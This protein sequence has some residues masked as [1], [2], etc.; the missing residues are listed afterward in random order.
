MK[1][2]QMTFDEYQ[3]L[4]RRTQNK[5]LTYVQRQYHALHGLV[6]E[7]GEIHGL[8]Q[9]IYQGHPL[10]LDDLEKEIGDLL[11]FV[12]ELCDVYDWSM[13]DVAVENI[14]KLKK[15][16]PEGFDA[17]RSVHREEYEDGSKEG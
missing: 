10:S 11:W 8:F 9:K 2:K 4:A 13:G 3:E 12:A 15:R 7:V 16:Y 1:T 6:S 5:D 14:E 17:E